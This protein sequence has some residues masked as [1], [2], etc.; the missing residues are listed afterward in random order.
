M[1]IHSR[2]KQ[3]SSTTPY[4]K[5]SVKKASGTPTMT[6]GD[7]DWTVPVSNI[8]ADWRTVLQPHPQPKESKLQE[9]QAFALLPAPLTKADFRELR[10]LKGYVMRPRLNANKYARR[11]G[12]HFFLFRDN[13]SLC[14]SACRCLPNAGITGVRHLARLVQSLL[15]P[16][17]LLCWRLTWSL[18]DMLSKEIL[19]RK[20]KQR[21]VYTNK[22]VSK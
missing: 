20:A 16:G 15:S 18:Q 1:Q 5:Q 2:P 22:Q 8:V 9:G 11:G 7:P 17:T 6:T 19:S 14:G 3:V 12:R 21:N 4:T 10:G 13:S